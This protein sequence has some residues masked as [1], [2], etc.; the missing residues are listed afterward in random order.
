MG[1]RAR[2]EVAKWDWRAAT[3]HL[4]NVQYPIAMAAAAAQYG[5]ALGRV[6]Q[7][8][9]AAQPPQTGGLTPRAA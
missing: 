9:L 6:A 4:L 3:M 7:D 2:Q 5:E 1:I 8:A